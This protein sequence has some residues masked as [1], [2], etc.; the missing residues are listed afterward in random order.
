[1]LERLRLPIVQA[2]L[3]GGASTPELTIAAGRAGALGF[4]AAGYLTADKL[5]DDIG[6]VRRAFTSA[7]GVNLFVPGPNTP[8]AADLR[9]YRERIRIEASAVNAEPGE[10]RWSD[11]DWQSKLEV[12]LGEQPAVVSF[13]FGCPERDVIN[14]LRRRAIEVWVTVTEPDEAERAA[15]AG[16]DALVVQ[17][18]EAGGHRA[19]FVDEDGVGEVGLLTLIRLVSKRV[20]LPLVA[21]GG[22]CDGYSIAAVLV[23]GARAAQVGSAFLDTLEAGTSPPHRERLR[24]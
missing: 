9:S 18:I 6:L 24:T 14:D 17:G 22:L 7:I 19:S 13:T 3:S 12:V 21:A 5:A 8:E 23:A 11:D 10:P 20:R 16:A 15:D 2:P 4:L 1:M